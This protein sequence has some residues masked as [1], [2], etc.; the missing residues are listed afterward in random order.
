MYVDL[1]ELTLAKEL[2]GDFGTVCAV[3]GLGVSH[4]RSKRIGKKP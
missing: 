1:D 4:E 3:D 2:T